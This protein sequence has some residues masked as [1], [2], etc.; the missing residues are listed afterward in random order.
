MKNSPIAPVTAAVSATKAASVTAVAPA[1]PPV[2]VTAERE[3]QATLIAKGLAILAVVAVHALALYPDS[4][5]TTSDN[6]LFFIFINQFSRFSVPLFLAVSGFGLA[7]KYQHKNV[8]NKQFIWTRIAK[9]LPQYLLWSVI[10]FGVLYF[11]SAWNLDGDSR[12]LERLLHGNV[13]YHLYFVPLIFQFY[14]LFSVVLS[15]IKS[16]KQL[17]VLVAASGIL[18][19]GW[20]LLLRYVTEAKVPGISPLINDQLQYRQLISWTFYFLLGIFLAQFNLNKIR[21]IK[22]ASL[23]ILLVTVL[24]LAWSVSDS[25]TLVEQTGRIVYATSFVRLP[26]FIYAT[27]VIAAIIIYGPIFLNF[28]KSLRGAMIAVGKYSYVI[29]LSHTLFLRIIEG[30]MSSGPYSLTL[31]NATLLFAVG[32]ALSV[33]ETR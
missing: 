9:L 28:K 2:S 12:F 20:F 24:G 14:L 7:R 23:G 17:A 25:I 32:I 18:Q 11:G 13:D 31:I 30:F 26:V 1:T 21:A 15:R 29:Y 10:L 3:K 6:R 19:I 27:G 4:I 33:A 5:Y 8:E 16:R 22:T